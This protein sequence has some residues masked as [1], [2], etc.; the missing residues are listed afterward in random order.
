MQKLVI[1]EQDAGQRLDKFLAKY[2]R[3][4]PKSFLYKMLRKKNIEL[5]GKKAEPGALLC[6]GDTVSL[7]LSEETIASFRGGLPGTDGAVSRNSGH[8]GQAGDRSA[9]RGLLRSGNE[10]KAGRAEKELLRTVSVIYEDEQILIADKPAGLLSQKAA[11]SDYS[12]NEYLLDRLQAQSD[13]PAET[14]GFRPSVCNRLDRNTSGLVTFAKTYQAARFLT[15]LFADRG[16]H[17]YYLALV[18]GEMT[19]A[20]RIEGWLRK[21]EA[22]NQVEVHSRPFAGADRIETAYEPLR[23]LTFGRA[24]TAATL[25]RVLLVTGKTHQIRA[26]LQSLGHPILGDPKY[27]DRD[28][29]RRLSAETGINH[30]FLHAWELQFPEKLPA[31]FSH[32]AGAGFRAPLPKCW[33]CVLGQDMA[34]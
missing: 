26:H 28:L 19:E 23:Q 2:L 1:S 33:A 5:N 13:I 14:H 24:R 11:A 10:H 17:K 34:V 20:E 4:A 7:W 9:G 25:L 18:A 15:G 29:N 8:E 30:Q 3:L 12:L 16:I 27:G 22:G 32:L 21:Q 6:G 31:A